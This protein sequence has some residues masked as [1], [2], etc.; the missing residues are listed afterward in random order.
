VAAG[1]LSAETEV[2]QEAPT[3]IESRTLLLQ[4]LRCAHDASLRYHNVI[5]PLL[6][7]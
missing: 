2:E 7:G 1:A 5:R 6:R 4:L 3:L